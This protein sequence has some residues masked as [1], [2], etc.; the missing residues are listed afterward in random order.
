[1]SLTALVLLALF[2]GIQARELGCAK[3][4]ESSVAHEYCS[5]VSKAIIRD[6]NLFS[7]TPFGTHEIAEMD[8]S[9]MKKICDKKRTCPS[10]NHHNCWLPRLPDQYQYVCN[11]VY[12]L[13]SSYGRC[14]RR[15]LHQRPESEN[16]QILLTDFSQTGIVKKCVLLDLHRDQLQADIKKECGD[17][18]EHSFILM[19]HD[20]GGFYNC[21]NE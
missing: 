20:I 11:R 15:M 12:A 9:S 4:D 19:K 5:D 1:M 6:F 13:R 14:M 7:E 10:T 17:N 2:H 3:V 21:F 8:T 16:L 18:A